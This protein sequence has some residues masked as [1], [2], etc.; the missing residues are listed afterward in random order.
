VILLV[1]MRGSSTVRM[2]GHFVEFGSSLMRIVVHDGSFL[3]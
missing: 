1:V 2:C 3:G